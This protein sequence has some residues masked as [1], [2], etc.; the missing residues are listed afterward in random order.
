MAS[1]RS[2]CR[3]TAGSSR[4]GSAA[5]GA[6]SI[7]RTSAAGT[8]CSVPRIGQ[9]RTIVPVGDRVFDVDLGH[10]RETQADR[11]E[12]AEVVLGLDGAEGGDDLGGSSAVRARDL[13]IQEAVVDDLSYDHVPSV[14]RL[15]MLPIAGSGLL[16]LSR[17]R[18]RSGRSP[19]GQDVVAD[20]GFDRLHA[21]LPDRSRPH[22]PR[23]RPGRRAAPPTRGGRSGPHWWPSAPRCGVSDRTGRGDIASTELLRTKVS[24]ESGDEKRAVPPVGSTWFEPAT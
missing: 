7:H 11:P 18:N 16:S 14:P 21:R 15:P 13:L 22:S 3:R 19:R 10:S 2:S 5:P 6:R 20:L 1:S 12:G 8:K 23:L 4:R 9:V 24:T 17:H